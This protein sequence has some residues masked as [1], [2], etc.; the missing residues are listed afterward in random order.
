VCG[1]LT[2]SASGM[3]MQVSKGVGE[4]FSEP[5]QSQG[6]KAV[7]DAMQAHL[8]VANVQIMA[9]SALHGLTKALSIA[10]RQAA[11]EAGA[12]EAVLNAMQA[13]LQEKSVQVLGLSALTSLCYGHDAAML[14]AT[15]GGALRVAVA[16][17]RAHPQN[18][19]LQLLGSVAL[20]RFGKGEANKH[21]AAEAGE[22]AVVFAA[23]KAFPN[24]KTIGQHLLDVLPTRRE[25]GQNTGRV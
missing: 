14:R 8:Q 23:V 3:C 6:V 15:E 12:I 22:R 24:I 17:M 19:G 1:V 2:L 10:G 4:F 13:H 20:I 25:R 9:C 5:L 7:V 18:E 11:A 16:A 21:R